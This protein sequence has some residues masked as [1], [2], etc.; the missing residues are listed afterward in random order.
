MI[1]PLKPSMGLLIKLGS[2][3]VHQEEL[4]SAKGH[5]VDKHALDSVRND[6]E[7]VEWFAQMNK[8]AVLPVKR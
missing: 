6:P 3:I 7:V 2:V 5:H 8:L 1:D 4:M